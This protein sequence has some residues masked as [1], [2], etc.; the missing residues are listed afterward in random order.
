M[1][2]ADLRRIIYTPD[3]DKS[4]A[5]KCSTE[6]FQKLSRNF[7]QFSGS[8]F[9]SSKVPEKPTIT[10]HKSKKI[11]MNR[12]VSSL[13]FNGYNKRG[14]DP[15]LENKMI[16]KSSVPYNLLTPTISEGVERLKNCKR[17]YSSEK[18]KSN[19]GP[20]N[21][22][23][24]ERQRS[25]SKKIIQPLVTEEYKRF[26]EKKMCSWDRGSSLANKGSASK[27][28]D[29]STKVGNLMNK[30]SLSLGCTTKNQNFDLL[31]GSYKYKKYRKTGEVKLLIE[32]TIANK[33]EK[34]RVELRAQYQNQ[35]RS[36]S[37]I[38]SPYY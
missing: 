11:L 25:T 19:I 10:E 23:V 22:I 20:D 4:I 34:K 32:N 12:N 15:I 2:K 1:L 26:N 9:S 21:T 6:P 3:L 28:K 24:E 7:S 37:A 16:N 17:L 27:P 13:T 30:S 31:L 18:F 38:K 5:G 8:N 36:Y 14:N 29:N 35:P 33:E